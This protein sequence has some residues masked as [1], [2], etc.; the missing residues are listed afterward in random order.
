MI[1]L[2]KIWIVKGAINNF[3]NFIFHLTHYNFFCNRWF[4][5]NFMLFDW[6]LTIILFFS[7][8]IL[9][10]FMANRINRFRQNCLLIFFN[11]IQR[12][13]LFGADIM[14]PPF[15]TWG[16]FDNITIIMLILQPRRSY[17]MLGRWFFLDLISGLFK[18]INIF[19]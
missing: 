15:L 9:I 2:R 17:I 10:L 1:N 5:I 13:F 3:N 12:W 16:M 6:T 4:L 14:Y 19:R 8:I 7:I 18:G 11:W